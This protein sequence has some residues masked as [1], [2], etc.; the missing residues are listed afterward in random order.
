MAEAAPKEYGSITPRLIVRYGPGGTI[1]PV[2]I[3]LGDS[4][5]MVSDESPEFNSR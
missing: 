3:Q 5:V 2:E 1:V 4:I